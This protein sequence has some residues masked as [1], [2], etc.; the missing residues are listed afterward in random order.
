MHIIWHPFLYLLR[1]VH[2]R[3][4]TQRDI[5]LTATFLCGHAAAR[6]E[7]R[8][9]V[10][11]E[12]EGVLDDI[13]AGEGAPGASK[14]SVG[15]FWRWEGME[16]LASSS[17]PLLRQTTSISFLGK[18]NDADQVRSCLQ[19][20]LDESQQEQQLARQH[21]EQVKVR[22]PQAYEAFWTQQVGGVQ[23]SEGAVTRV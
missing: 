3:E 2:A 15:A 22:A 11:T 17:H 13:D 4:E 23:G 12:L 16:T 9:F 6:R 19:L 20:V 21:L 8:A 14:A 5:A 18:T 1:S 10:E 7:L